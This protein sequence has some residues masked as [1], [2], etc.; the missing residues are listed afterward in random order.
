VGRTGYGEEHA[1]LEAKRLEM[2]HDVCLFIIY[3]LNKI[4]RSF[5]I[6]LKERKHRRESNVRSSFAKVL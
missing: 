5:I 3:S 4:C 6:P 2:E 1:E